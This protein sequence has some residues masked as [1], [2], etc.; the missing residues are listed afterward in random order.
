MLT[1]DTDIWMKSK[2]IDLIDLVFSAA[3]ILFS[4]VRFVVFPERAVT[5]VFVD[6]KPGK[7]LM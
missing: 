4:L 5:F 7:T 1:T 2:A 3:C 6:V